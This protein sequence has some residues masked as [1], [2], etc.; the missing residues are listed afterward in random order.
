MGWPACSESGVGALC[1]SRSETSV[2]AVSTDGTTA[3]EWSLHRVGELLNRWHLNH[4]EGIVKG[5]CDVSTSGSRL[6]AVSNGCLSILNVNAPTEEAIVL[7]GIST[8]DFDD[9]RFV[10]GTTDGLVTIH[11]F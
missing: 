6:G 9:D 7:N 5:Q 4:R 2:F 8:V 1:L 3:S 10:A 11:N